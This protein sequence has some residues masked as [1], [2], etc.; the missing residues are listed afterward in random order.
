M[1]RD[2]IYSVLRILENT[3]NSTNIT[4]ESSSQTLP[5]EYVWGSAIGVSIGFLLLSFILTSMIICCVKD[6][7]DQK[8]LAALNSSLISMA[9]GSLVGDSVIHIIP[10]FFKESND[11]PVEIRPNPHIT[12]LVLVIGF[13]VF[14]TIEKI[15]LL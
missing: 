13:I 9:I 10:D 8:C 3:P 6:R 1:E 14:F 11:I 2:S 15:F 12:S 7:V 5:E 4:I